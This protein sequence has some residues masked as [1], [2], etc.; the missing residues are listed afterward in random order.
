MLSLFCETVKQ[1]GEAYS[2]STGWDIFLVA[3][4]SEL[5][6]LTTPP[7]PPAAEL[8]LL[9]NKKYMYFISGNNGLP[10]PPIWTSIFS[11]ECFT[12]ALP[13]DNFSWMI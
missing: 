12:S 8:K 9:M 10:P 2:Y 7:P 4:L 3:A 6:G 5:D 13:N 11:K 1:D